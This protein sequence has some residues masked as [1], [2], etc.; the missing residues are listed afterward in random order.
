MEIEEYKK[1][2]ASG[3]EDAYH[4]RTDTSCNEFGYGSETDGESSGSR[5]GAAGSSADLSDSEFLSLK[6]PEVKIKCCRARINQFRGR[7][8][9]IKEKMMNKSEKKK[10]MKKKKKGKIYTI[11]GLDDHKTTECFTKSV[12]TA[13]PE[14]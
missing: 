2:K 12:G 8:E 1:T 11:C 5:F 9:I 4:S 3:E 13:S 14:V 6:P 7:L 10:M